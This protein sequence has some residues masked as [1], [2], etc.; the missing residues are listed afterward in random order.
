MVILTLKF[1]ACKIPLEICSVCLA[2]VEVW[3]RLLESG[4]VVFPPIKTGSGSSVA[5]VN[6]FCFSRS[7][8]A[9]SF[10]NLSHSLINSGSSGLFCCNSSS[11]H[12]QPSSISWG[13]ISEPGARNRWPATSAMTRPRSW[14]PAS[15]CRLWPWGISSGTRGECGPSP[16]WLR[17]SFQSCA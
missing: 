15:S 1:A 2:N 4:E 11:G 6:I 12:S 8:S 13:T 17:Q 16:A 7:H 10:L 3:I 9:S 5:P 14:R